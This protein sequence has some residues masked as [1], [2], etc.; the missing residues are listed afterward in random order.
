MLV[1]R[2]ISIGFVIVGFI[3]LLSSLIAI[4]EFYSMKNTIVKL[5]AD[6]VD[7]INTANKLLDISDEYNYKVLSLLDEYS[8]IKVSD[9]EAIKTDQRFKTSLRKIQDTL[10]TQQEK[11][12]C[13]SVKFA[14]HT[15][16][17]TI[18]E[19]P[20]IIDS[21]DFQQKQSWYFKTLYPRYFQLRLYIDKLG[22]SS[23]QALHQHS[24]TLGDSFYRSLMPCVVAVV[25]GIILLFLFNYFFNFYFINPLDKIT[26]GISKYIL[27]HKSYDYNLQSGDEMEQLNNS[28]KEIIEENRKL[29]KDKDL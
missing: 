9:I 4:F 22:L 3:L 5:V 24:H 10:Y 23:Q 16:I 14:Y 21:L 15:Y 17:Y 20:T 8:E 11:Q 2:K 26:K 6:D 25:I 27:T 1:R 12:M 29:I 28:V 7:N 13:D 18:S 19:L